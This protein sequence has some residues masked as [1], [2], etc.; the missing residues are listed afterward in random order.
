LE[1]APLGPRTDYRAFIDP[2]GG[3]GGDSYGIDELKV[4]GSS[5][6]AEMRYEA[7]PLRSRV[8]QSP[9]GVVAP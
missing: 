9:V 8:V 7:V 4:I 6:N 1:L 5:K 2:S 3:V